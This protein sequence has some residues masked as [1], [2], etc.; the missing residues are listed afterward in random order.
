LVAQVLPLNESG[1]QEN[2]LKICSG[3]WICISTG[4]CAHELAAHP[5]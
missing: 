4:S 3:D 1:T 2:K 5:T